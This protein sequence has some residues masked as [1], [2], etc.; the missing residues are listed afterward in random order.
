MIVF[1]FITL[2]PV[3]VIPAFLHA[4]ARADPNLRRAIAWR[5][6]VIST[7]TVLAIALFGGQLISRWGISDRAIAITGAVI[8]FIWSLHA[9]LEQINPNAH[10]EP[11]E[12]PTLELA[13]IPLTIPA[14]ITPAGVTAI[15]F[16]TMAAPPGDHRLMAILAGLL[17]A[18]MILDLM[19]MLGARAMLKAMGGPVTLK[20]AG[21][22]LA[23]LQATLAIEVLIR[24]IQKLT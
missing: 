15:L 20:V 21:G 11:P 9:L 23:V 6:F 19:S 1:F 22:V 10:R 24:N 17:I 16:F 12:E 13:A 4:T 7:V 18:I 5:A 3:K 8:L 14:I 2:G